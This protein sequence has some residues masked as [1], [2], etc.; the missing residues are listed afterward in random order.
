M[1]FTKAQCKAAYDHLLDNILEK[2]NT[3]PLKQSLT[4]FGIEDVVDFCALTDADIETKLEY[5]T[6]PVPISRMDMARV[7]QLLCFIDHIQ[8]NGNSLSEASDWM[9]LTRQ[10]FVEYC[11]GPSYRPHAGLTRAAAPPS[12]TTTPPVSNT[13]SRY[14][15]ADL[16]RRGIK[17]DP[18]LFPVLKEEKLNDTWHRSF[19]NQA[20]AQ[21]VIQVLDPNYTPSNA[22]EQELFDEK[23]KYIY[24]VLEQKVLT[25]RGKGFIREHEN[26]YDA[27]KVYQ[28]LVDH[29]LKSTKAMIDSSSI[30]SYITSVRLGS[31]VWKGTTE[32]FIIHWEN[33]VRLYERQMPM[34]DHFSD[35]QKRTML[36]NA[37]AP[38]D[39][40]RQI[41]N[42]ADLEKTKT[43]RTLTFSEY[44]SLLLSAS[45]AYDEEF[46]PKSTKQRHVY[47]HDIGDDYDFNDDHDAE[48]YDIDVSVREIQANAHRR[49]P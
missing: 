43:G 40:L 17:R 15:P 18:S 3:S 33:Q 36:E 23:Q 46:K 41:K 7:K 6:P 2:D 21:D 49:M 10:D 31:G 45:A 30:L 39:E 9:N 5:G 8:D 44:T 25:D 32:A 34:T 22:E 38:I 11:T 27:Q 16:F 26:D 4:A 35:G 20:R 28:K 47:V 13:T 12:S 48:D 14:T 42:N 29:H 24:A 1:V 37:V 19:A